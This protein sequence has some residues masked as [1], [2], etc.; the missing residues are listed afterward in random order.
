MGA[1]YL[2][3]RTDG[4]VKH[5]AAIKLIHTRSPGL[6]ERFLRERPILASLSHPNIAALLDAGTLADGVPYFAREYVGG[7]AR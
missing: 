2:A 1:V 4:V 3:E 6:V 5:Q 7:K